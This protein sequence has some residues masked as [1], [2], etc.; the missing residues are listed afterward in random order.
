MLLFSRETS[1][2]GIFSKAFHERRLALVVC[3]PEYFSVFE[4]TFKPK[5][6]AESDE[7]PVSL[8]LVRTSAIVRLSGYQDGKVVHGLN[9]DFDGDRVI[10]SGPGAGV[11]APADSTMDESSEKAKL[12]AGGALEGT[13]DEQAIRY[14]TLLKRHRHLADRLHLSRHLR[15]IAPEAISDRKAI[16]NVVDIFS[17][18]VA[19]YELITGHEIERIEDTGTQD[20]LRDIHLHSVRPVKPIVSLLSSIPPELCEVVKKTVSLDPDDRYSNMCSVLHD[21][22]K[23]KEICQGKLSGNA[24]REYQPGYIDV[25]SRFK[26]PPGMLDRNR[27]E[28]E[29]DQA[30]QRVKTT[31]KVETMC[32]WGPSGSGKS[33]LME[34]WARRR[35]ASNAGQECLVGWAKMDQHLV[36]PLGAFVAIFSSLL[37]RIFSD[38]LENPEMWRKRIANALSVNGNVFLSLIPPAYRDLL[39]E[40]EVDAVDTPGPLGV[41][42]DR[43]VKQFR[44]WSYGLLRLFATK[45]RPLIL[46]LD[47]YQWIGAEKS[48]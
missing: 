37:D 8:D 23:V 46:V 11:F 17:W 33:K 42:W 40:P 3:R 45:S 9:G 35:E 48:L 29:I 22:H 44:S 28:D 38:P 34:I 31:G 36:K 16:G 18:G 14:V 10:A 19:A 5:S 2:Y 43:Y 26:V 13:F 39:L 7:Q 27:E 12:T 32:C 20:M 47:D 15:Y 6:S 4:K 24:R 41:D 21:L 30:Y 25:M 1:V